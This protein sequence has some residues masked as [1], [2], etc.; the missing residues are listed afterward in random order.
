MVDVRL[1]SDAITALELLTEGRAP[2]SLQ[3]LAAG[4][5][6]DCLSHEQE[7]GSLFGVHLH[8]TAQGLFRIARGDHWRLGPEE[9]GRLMALIDTVR[10]IIELSSRQS[11][12]LH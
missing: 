6:L 10:D 5:G 8:E 11:T 4:F 9:C 3:A 1:L 12:T 7:S 2:D